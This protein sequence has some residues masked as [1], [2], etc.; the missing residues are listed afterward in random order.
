M[1]CSN[2]N[3]QHDDGQFHPKNDWEFLRMTDASGVERRV[4]AIFCEEQLTELACH[5]HWCTINNYVN[6]FNP[7]LEGPTHAPY[8]RMCQ[9]SETTTPSCRVSYNAGYFT[10]SYD[11]H[12]NQCDCTSVN[13]SV[14]PC[15]VHL[16][17]KLGIDPPSPPAEPSSPPSPLPSFPPPSLPPPP[18]APCQY[19]CAY[20]EDFRRKHHPDDGFT[21]G[22][23]L[24]GY[25]LHYKAVASVAVREQTQEWCDNLVNSGAMVAC[26]VT[27]DQERY[28]AYQDRAYGRR[29][30][31]LG[32]QELSSPSSVPSFSSLS[33]MVET[34]SGFAGVRQLQEASSAPFGDTFVTVGGDT[35]HV[36]FACYCESHPPPAA[37]PPSSPPPPPLAPDVCYSSRVDDSSFPGLDD[38]KSTSK[39]NDFGLERP[40]GGYHLRGARCPEYSRQYNNG[41]TQAQY[42]AN[43]DN[44]LIK[45]NCVNIAR[46]RLINLRGVNNDPWDCDTLIARTIYDADSNDATVQSGGGKWGEPDDNNVWYEYCRFHDDPAKV[47]DRCQADPDRPR[48]QCPTDQGDPGRRLDATPAVVDE[49]ADEPEIVP[50]WRVALDPQDLPE[51]VLDR[52]HDP[53]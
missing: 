5:A 4:H 3:D 11:Y 20:L 25:Q 39:T 51:V 18:L 1:T 15:P 44:N 31:E 35:K 12:D 45:S 16:G 21:Y 17:C 26:H 42:D 47:N 43:C 6:A 13:T 10:H 14:T 52:T 29:A 22:F 36:W 49:A 46:A 40:M 2:D 7:P 50:A 48:F 30:A 38:K 33:S 24:E 19:D 53:E 34:V 27:Q 23:T 32:V 37:P 8:G 28:Y 9:W 41:W